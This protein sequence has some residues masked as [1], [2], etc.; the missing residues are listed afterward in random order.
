MNSATLFQF[1]LRFFLFLN[2]VPT[3]FLLF[4]FLIRMS[5]SPHARRKDHNAFDA[6]QFNMLYYAFAVMGMLIVG[7][8]LL[9]VHIRITNQAKK[10]R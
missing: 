4:F 1:L 2:S 10:K 6:G 8:V 5:M 7:A 3:P 9:N